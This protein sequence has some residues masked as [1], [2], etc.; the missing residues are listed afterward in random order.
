MSLTAM[1]PTCFSLG[2]SGGVSYLEVCDEVLKIVQLQEGCLALRHDSHG[3]PQQDLGSVLRQ[4]DVQ[5]A[6]GKWG[7]EGAAEERQKPLR[8]IQDRR[9]PMLL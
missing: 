6:S 7:W 8:C 1:P 2:I 5:D 4:Q 3:H 9:G